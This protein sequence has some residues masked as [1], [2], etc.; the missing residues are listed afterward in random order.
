MNLLRIPRISRKY[1]LI[2]IILVAFVGGGILSYQYWIGASKGVKPPEVKLPFGRGEKPIKTDDQGRVVVETVNYPK[3]NKGIFM[4]LNITNDKITLLSK[5]EIVDGYP[6]S[7][8]GSY[9]FLARVISSSS[10]V[11]GEYGFGDPRIILGEQ[12]YQG[13]TWIDNVDFTL[14]VPYFEGAQRVEVFSATKLMLSI[15]ISKLV[16]R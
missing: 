2:G 12:G 16:A 11:L 14:V 4:R 10:D 5:P 9:T 1:I 7:L 3:E 6:N 8:P 15:D 13:P